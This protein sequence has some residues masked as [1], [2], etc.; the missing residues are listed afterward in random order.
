M[1][2]FYRNFWK[3]FLST[4]T[5]TELAVLARYKDDSGNMNAL[6][7]Y[8][9][10][11]EIVARNLVRQLIGD[12]VCVSF[13]T[14]FSLRY[15]KET[16]DDIRLLDEMFKKAPKLKRSV[17]VFR[18]IVSETGG[19]FADLKVGDEVTSKSFVSTSFN[20]KMSLS[21]A[22][23][24]DPNKTGTMLQIVIPKGKKFI[25]L[26]GM[27]HNS[28]YGDA[29]TFGDLMKDKKFSHDEFELI[30]DRNTKFKAVKSQKFRILP[31]ADFASQDGKKRS[32]RLLTLEVLDQDNEKTLPSDQEVLGKVGR[33]VFDFS[34]P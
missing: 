15:L 6:L 34:Q 3:N 10:Q 17:T 27:P 8:Q 22:M 30:L 9:E 32:I 13:L 18:G 2:K 28:R 24:S 12:K 5:C 14:E 7:W 33:L 1:V 19:I 11:P 20:V 23:H 4:L 25:L 31:S 29:K 16:F 26:P 21:F